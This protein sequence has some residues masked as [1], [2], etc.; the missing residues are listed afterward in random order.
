MT[1]RVAFT[2]IE[3]VAVI[4]VLGVMAASAAAWFAYRLVTGRG[5]NDSDSR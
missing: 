3:G 1:D 2:L 4:A 5:L